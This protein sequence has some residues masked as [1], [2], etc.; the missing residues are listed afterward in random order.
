[1]I[2][3]DSEIMESF[4]GGTMKNSL[5][6]PHRTARAE[7]W[8]HYNQRPMPF[9]DY[10]HSRLQMVRADDWRNSTIALIRAARFEENYYQ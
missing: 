3:T 1:M 4:G 7:I 6:R 10:I 8:G 2:N 5:D 9:A